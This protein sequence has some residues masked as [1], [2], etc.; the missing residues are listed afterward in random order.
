MDSSRLSI[1]GKPSY[2]ETNIQVDTSWLDS[3]C[4]L[5]ND[6][7][8]LVTGLRH[9]SDFCVESQDEESD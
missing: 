5:S 6:D 8:E 4:N 3:M 2:K 1:E 9:D 7:R